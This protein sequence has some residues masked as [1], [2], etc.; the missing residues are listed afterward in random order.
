MLTPKPNAKLF[1]LFKLETPLAAL[2]RTEPLLTT[3]EFVPIA[4]EFAKVSVPALPSTNTRPV[5]LF[6]PWN[7]SS[8]TPRFVIWPFPVMLLAIVT[9][10]KPAPRKVKLVAKVNWLL[11]MNAP[12][13]CCTTAAVA[14]LM[15]SELPVSVFVPVVALWK[16]I[17]LRVSIVV[18]VAVNAVTV[19]VPNC[20][21]NVAEPGELGNDGLLVQDPVIVSLHFPLAWPQTKSAALVN[22]A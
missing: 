5:K 18:L 21:F 9:L 20:S 19:F 7:T 8:Y 22:P 17:V 15:I 16:V 10:P 1:P 6:E 12:L 14:P 2:A 3:I 13:F 11:T 4:Y